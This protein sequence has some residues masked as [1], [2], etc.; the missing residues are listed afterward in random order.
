MTIELSGTCPHVSSADRVLHSFNNCT[1]KDL[2]DFLILAISSS[3]LSQCSAVFI[4]RNLIIG[5]M[6]GKGPF[7]I[8][9]S[10]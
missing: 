4:R 8:I 10:V 7:F 5:R 6:N 9:L 3:A 1:T 2:T